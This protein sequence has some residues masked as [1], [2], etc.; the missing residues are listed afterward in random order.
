MN[1]RRACIAA[2]IGVL[3]CLP[4]IATAAP[5]TQMVAVAPGVELEV[6][7][8]GGAG[9]PLVF[10]AGFGGTAHTFEGFAERF[11]D[12]HHVYAITRRGFGLSSHPEPTDENFTVA[13]LAADVLA[14]DAKLGLVRPVLVG[15]SVAGQELSEIGTRH[16]DEVGGLIYLDASNSQALYGPSSDVLYPIAGEVRDD[17]ARLVASQPSEARRIIAKLRAELPRLQRG[18]AWYEAA[19]EGA[20]DNPEPRPPAEVKAVQDALVRGARLHHGLQVPI[21]AIV[22]DPPACEPNC[23]SAASRAYAAE[24]AAQATDFAHA[25]PSATVVRLPYADHFIW[26]SNPEDVA[27]AMQAFLAKLAAADPR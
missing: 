17:L 25:N 1:L 12:G 3:S 2:I 13:R 21:L 18:L 16:P 15:H 14:V 11:T 9:P 8:W 7:D 26:E 24:N 23:A 22:A 10:L 19:I 5:K 4:G 6:L 27:R 20:P